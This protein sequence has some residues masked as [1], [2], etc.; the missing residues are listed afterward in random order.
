M[1]ECVLLVSFEDL[2]QEEKEEE[3]EERGRVGA[4]VGK[5]GCKGEAARTAAAVRKGGR[6]K[7]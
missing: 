7:T 3:E 5:E 6:R 4:S 1:C 2:Q